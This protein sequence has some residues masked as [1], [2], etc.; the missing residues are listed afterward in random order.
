MIATV[1]K[2]SEGEGEKD[3]SALLSSQEQAI[4]E[5]IL[6]IQDFYQLKDHMRLIQIILNKK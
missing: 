2:S 4:M 6:S 1:K 5:S 3:M